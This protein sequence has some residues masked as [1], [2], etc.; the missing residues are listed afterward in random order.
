MVPPKVDGSLRL[1]HGCIRVTAVIAKKGTSTLVIRRIFD[2]VTDR[3]YTGRL[4]KG[5]LAV[6]R[7]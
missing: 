5:L 3:L 6:L 7:G 2:L 1:Y 4:V